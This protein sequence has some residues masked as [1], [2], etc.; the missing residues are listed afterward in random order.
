MEMSGGK[1]AKASRI[2]P[3]GWKRDKDKDAGMPFVA[4]AAILLS[5]LC[6][7]LDDVDG[8]RSASGERVGTVEFVSPSEYRWCCW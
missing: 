4:S 6:E 1:F 5:V 3:L 7:K 8:R 2:L